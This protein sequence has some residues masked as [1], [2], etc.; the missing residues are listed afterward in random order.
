MSIA[1]PQQLFCPKTHGKPLQHIRKTLSVRHFKNKSRLAFGKLRGLPSSGICNRDESQYWSCML[2]HAP[3]LC[4]Y[5]RTGLL[6]KYEKYLRPRMCAA[7]LEMQKRVTTIS[8]RSKHWCQSHRLVHAPILHKYGRTM[9]L[10][11]SVKL[12]R[13]QACAALSG[14]QRR[15]TMS[16]IRWCQSHTFLTVPHIP[17]AFTT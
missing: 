9:L 10:H 2:V 13:P 12:R 5:G 14:M 4:R 1:S 17:P 16:S 6:H 7:L 3:I 15:A 8:V 11:V